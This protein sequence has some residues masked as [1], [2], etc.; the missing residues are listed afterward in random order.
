MKR[1][2]S[3]ALCVLFVFSA[4]ACGAPQQKNL[5]MAT[6]GDSGVYYAYGS[7]IAGVF[8]EAIDGMTVTAVTTGASKDNANRLNKGEADIA[9]L[10]NDVMDY[11][12]NAKELFEGGAPLTNIATIG[13]LYP[14]TIQIVAS[15]ASGITSIKDLAGK[16]VSVGDLGSGTEANARQILTAHGLTYDDLGQ[17]QYLG[18]GESSTAIQQLTLDAAFLTAGLPT[19]AIIDLNSQTAVVLVSLDPAA[20]DQLIHDYPF[21]TPYHVEAGAYEGM[22]SAETVAVLATMACRKDLDEDTVYAIT[23]TLFESKDKLQHNKASFLSAESAINGASI[24][25]HP[26]A[27]KY[28]KELGLI[29]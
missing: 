6:G 8:T 20:I 22:E 4:A 17:V 24:A 29:Q 15:K 25:M 26:G 27:A 2:L 9:I 3:F 14:E 1:I 13:T 11:A 7:I 19:P 28:Y 23:K 12:F 18:F 16:R 10:Q 5:T 21:Y